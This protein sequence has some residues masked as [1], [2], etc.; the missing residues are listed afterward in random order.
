MPIPTLT[1]QNL[2]LSKE[3]SY[4]KM[5][6]GISI[7]LWL[8]LVVFTLGM[9]LIYGAFIALFI[10]LGNGLII[11]H[12]RSESV[13]VTEEQMPAL[14]QTY[15]EVVSQLQL[16]HIPPLYIVQSHGFLNAF[17][18]RH[19]GRD[20]VVIYS[21]MLEACGV[22]TPQVRFILG[23]ELGHVRRQ[24]VKKKMALFPGM[25]AP[26]LGNAY[27]R[28]CEASC[29]RHGA[30]AAGDAEASAQAMLILSGGRVAWQHMSPQAFSQ[31][32]QKERGFF[33]SWHELT[34]G[35]PTLSQRTYNL[36]T[37]EQSPEPAGL[38]RHPL[39]YPFAFF[40]A[41]GRHGS[42]GNILV[43]VAIVAILFG[44]ALPAFSAARRQAM[45]AR[46]RH[47]RLQQDQSAR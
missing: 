40:T 8:L 29:D 37:I 19:S 16:D 35:Y 44:I 28:A 17:A 24:H 27:S 9:A 41:G 2:T 18:T 1:L 26:L 23:H 10:W 42:G 12:L 25:L 7:I 38:P 30:F 47:E 20:F 6:I 32:Y 21:D 5:V 34:S 43:T 4:L 46:A 36:L 31:Q 39:A 45:T 14:F 11:A 15:R 33:V 13:L 3:E 22:D